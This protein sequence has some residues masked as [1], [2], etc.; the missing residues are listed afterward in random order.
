MKH[1]AIFL[2]VLIL[3]GCHNRGSGETPLDTGMIKTE[4]VRTAIA[5]ITVQAILNPQP[6]LATT[7]NTPYPNDVE[8]NSVDLIETP[9]SFESE[10]EI[11]TTDIP[12]APVY[13][14]TIDMDASLP[15]DGPQRIGEKN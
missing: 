11:E 3:I 5:E 2:T 10:I 9:P 13:A 4:A 12:V 1:L 6:P 14:C 7:T 8:M 15:K